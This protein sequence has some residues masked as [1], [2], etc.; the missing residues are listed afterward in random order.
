YDAALMAGVTVDGARGVMLSNLAVVDTGRPEYGGI[1]PQGWV[2][3]I[4]IVNG[5]SA[6]V[7]RSRIE[8]SV[9][10]LGSAA[11][12]HASDSRVFIEDNCNGALD[13][14]TGRCTGSCG[15]N[16]PEL[17]EGWANAGNDYAILL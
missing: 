6:T 15:A 12:I 17:G 1:W 2:Y 16:G 3:G 8:G 14:A 5:A 11:G 9:S 13:P 10:N 7:T 4:Q